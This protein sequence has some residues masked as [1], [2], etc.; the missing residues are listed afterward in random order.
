LSDKSHQ[1]DKSSPGRTPDRGQLVSITEA[2]MLLGVSKMTVR[3]RVHSKTWPSGRCGKK[4]LLPR[5]FVEGAVAAIEAGC[6]VD[7]DEF[8]ATFLA[9]SEAA[10]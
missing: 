10:A 9:R 7:V 5:S 2:A 6:G 4:H 3:R 8:A 1:G